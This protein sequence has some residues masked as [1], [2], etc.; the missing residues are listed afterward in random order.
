MYWNAFNCICMYLTCISVYPTALPTPC[1]ECI[2]SVFGVYLEC[3]WSV[4]EYSARI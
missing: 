4:S 3:I 2:W 1:S